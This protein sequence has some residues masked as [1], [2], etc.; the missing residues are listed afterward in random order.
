MRPARVGTDGPCSPTSN[1]TTASDTRAW[2]VLGPDS[3]ARVTSPAPQA[4]WGE[5]VDADPMAGP[6]H[7]P[8][9]LDCVCRADGWVDA[10]RLYEMPGGRRLVLPLVRKAIVGTSGHS[11]LLTVQASYPHGWGSGGILAPGGT[12][13]QDVALVHADLAA[14]P[15][16]RTLLRPGFATAPAWRKGWSQG[17]AGEVEIPLTTHVLDLSG[18]LNEVWSKRFSSK[19]R[20]GI[21]NARRKAD[22]AGLEIEVGSS[23]QLVADLYTVYLRWLDRRALERRVPQ[24]VARWRG[25]R[26]EPLVRFQTVAATF[27]ERCWIWVARLDGTPVAAAIALFHAAVG[28]GW[29]AFSDRELAGP[30]R[31]HELMQFLAVEHACEIGCRYFD[32]GHSGGVVGLVHVKNRFGAT[33]HRVCEYAFERV[34]ISRLESGLIGLRGRVESHVLAR[35]R[36]Q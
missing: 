1:L 6:S 7:L 36:R 5:I 20:T 2:D 11:T 35:Y 32:M 29:R 13:S 16:L 18:G 28:V 3:S 19:A 8:A 12:R 30:L 23:P 15:G 9:W 17:R 14:D 25:V 31:T 34:P 21:R 22:K 24:P 10:S 27:G 4:V 33:E 26:A